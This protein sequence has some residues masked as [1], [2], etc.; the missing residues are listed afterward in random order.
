IRDHFDQVL[1]D[2]NLP[3]NLVFYSDGS[4][5]GPLSGNASVHPT[6][7]APQL[8]TAEQAQQQ[9]KKFDKYRALAQ[10]PS[11]LAKGK[12]LFTT[13]CLVC[14]QHAGSGGNIGPALDG[15]G[16]KDIDSILRNLVTPSAAME[17]GYRSYQILTTSGKFYSGLFVSE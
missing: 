10:K 5:W 12:Q 7:E 13:K 2:E 9:A 11:D 16:L 15:I 14:H 4:E 8:L 1:D 3:Q 17:G 6:L